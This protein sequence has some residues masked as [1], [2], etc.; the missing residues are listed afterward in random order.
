MKLINAFIVVL[1]TIFFLACQAIAIVVV[2]PI[3]LLMGL[4]AGVGALANV[5]SREE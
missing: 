4:F 3:M 1:V 5:L 2:A